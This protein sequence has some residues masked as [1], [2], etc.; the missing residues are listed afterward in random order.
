[1]RALVLDSETL[2]RLARATQANPPGV[3]H[4][5]VRAAANLESR[6]LV[7]AA[8]LAELYRGGAYDQ[9]LD[10]FLSRHE[11]IQVVDTTRS[12]A[13][14][15]GH[16]LA[17]I[18]AGSESHVDACVVATALAAGGAVIITG[19]TNDLG[20]LASPHPQVDIISC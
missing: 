5:W 12:L 16:L 10:S 3:V 20:C 19:D 17:R 1:M 7:P 11:G 8:V 9:T 2:S 18:K 4:S 13:K 15:V 14:Q 6:V